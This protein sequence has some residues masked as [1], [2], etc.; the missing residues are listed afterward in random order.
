[1]TVI[2]DTITKVKVTY[3]SHHSNHKPEICCLRVPNEVKNVV[4]A[5]LAEG[6]MIE[7]ILDDVRDSITGTIERGHLMNR[8]DVHNIEYKLN[9]MH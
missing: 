5:K 8:Q 6:V 9:L 1:M 7:R 4:T 3:C 2:E